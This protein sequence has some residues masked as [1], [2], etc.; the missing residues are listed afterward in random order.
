V[1][2]CLCLFK[3][4]RGKGKK[5]GTSVD[6][7]VSLIERCRRET[8]RWCL[9]VSLQAEKRRRK[10]IKGDWKRGGGRKAGGNLRMASLMV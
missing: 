3:R 5:V 10:E 6:D 2:K 9:A 4:L 1:F 7:D 8:D